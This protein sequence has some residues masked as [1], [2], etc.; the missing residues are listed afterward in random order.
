M[1]IIDNNPY[2]YS[3]LVIE[4][5]F[6][7]I[8][9][10]KYALQFLIAVWVVIGVLVFYIDLRKYLIKLRKRREGVDYS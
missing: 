9:E 3:Y 4:D 10:P 5:E 2:S 8:K 7:D 6:G 1:E